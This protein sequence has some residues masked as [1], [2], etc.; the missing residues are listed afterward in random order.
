M[1]F[2]SNLLFYIGFY[3]C[4]APLQALWAVGVYAESEYTKKPHTRT[5]I[6]TVTHTLDIK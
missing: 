6:S 3:R 4:S 5:Y 1:L 2:Y